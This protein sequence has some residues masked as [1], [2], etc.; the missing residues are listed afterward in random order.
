MAK[1]QDNHKALK[2]YARQLLLNMGFKDSEIIDEYTVKTDG[3]KKS[4]RVDVAGIKPDYKVAI[5]C[6]VTDSDKL[7]WEKLFFDEVIALPFLRINKDAGLY[8]R[9]IRE[10]NEKIAELNKKLEEKNQQLKQFEALTLQSSW[11][12]IIYTLITTLLEQFER[13]P[14][15]VSDFQLVGYTSS[16]L[17]RLKEWKTRYEEL[18]TERGW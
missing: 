8:E 3:M 15:G 17:Y 16:L 12:E 13:R 18:K 6:G 11:L 9:Q 7:I 10:L 14:L 4:F 2:E 1:S 5:E